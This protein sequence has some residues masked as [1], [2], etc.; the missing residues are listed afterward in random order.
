MT[1]LYYAPVLTQN[2]LVRSGQENIERL[3]AITIFGTEFC[4]S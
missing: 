2:T 3:A 4:E 1:N